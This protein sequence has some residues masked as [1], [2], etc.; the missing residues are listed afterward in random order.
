LDADGLTL[1]CAT[2]PEL[3]AGARAGLPTALIGL[4]GVNG[5]PERDLISFGLAGAL[6]DD[7]PCGTLLDGVRVVD[8]AGEMLWQGEPL[9]VP[10]ARAA[11]IVGAQR[12]VDTPGERRALA[13]RTGA[14]AVDLESGVLAASGRLAG[15]LRVV[16]DTPERTLHGICNAVTPRGDYDW[17]GIAKA[18][19]REPL[20]FAQAAADG[21][22]ALRALRRAAE[23][24][25][26]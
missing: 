23:A 19:A 10:G 11:T 3:E 17:V 26:A 4:G 21:K 18:F 25:A 22:R 5:L 14:D 2:A 15:V 24:L 20:G 16:S 8:E 6:G 7:L 1:A 12:V 13:E 9:G